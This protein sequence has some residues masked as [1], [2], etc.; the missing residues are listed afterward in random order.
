MTRTPSILDNPD[1]RVFS[2]FGLAIYDI[3]TLEVIQ[4]ISPMPRGGHLKNIEGT[5]QGYGFGL[6]T[7]RVPET[8]RKKFISGKLFPVSDPRLSIRLKTPYYADHPFEGGTELPCMP[9][10]S[11]CD[12]I[13]E[14][15]TEDGVRYR[16][17]GGAVTMRAMSTAGN[18]SKK[19]YSDFT[20]L[21]KIKF[22]ST[23]IDSKTV[24]EIKVVSP[25][26]GMAT[27]EALII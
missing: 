5:F 24:I 20:G 26:L 9:R 15:K 22:F 27:V 6:F 18:L 4:I 14:C 3:S 1:E 7:G 8:K 23:G 16:H 13:I 21:S 12:V 2:P 17:R 25:V 19:H 10:D 11:Q